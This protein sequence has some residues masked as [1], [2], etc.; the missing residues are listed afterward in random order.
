M[1]LVTLGVLLIFFGVSLAPPSSDIPQV[2]G[3]M[4]LML[5]GL[6]FL[7]W[8]APR[9]LNYLLSDD[10]LIIQV[11]TGQTRLSYHNLTAWRTT[12]GLGLRLLGTGLFGYYTGKFTFHDDLP[13]TVLA[14]SS[15][16]TGGV[17]VQS[18]NRTYFLTPADPDAFL[19]ELAMRGAKVKA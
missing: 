1:W 18:E 15:N 12:G 2:R 10:A 11:L 3:L 19:R 13:K 4:I 8:F 9:R 14:A 7:F 16:T 6:A 5:V 17:L